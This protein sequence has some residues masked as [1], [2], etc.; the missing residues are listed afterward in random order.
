M[1]RPELLFR[2]ARPRPS[3]PFAP[4]RSAA[5]DAQRL[6]SRGVAPAPRPAVRAALTICHRQIVRARLNPPGGI[7]R[8]RQTTVGGGGT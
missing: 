8:L 6:R 1:K 7:L 2:H 4:A 5:A 3:A